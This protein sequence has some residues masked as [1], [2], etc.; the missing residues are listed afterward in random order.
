LRILIHKKKRILISVLLRILIHRS[1]DTQ[2][3]REREREREFFCT[4]YF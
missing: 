2:R 1:E 3:E 4:E